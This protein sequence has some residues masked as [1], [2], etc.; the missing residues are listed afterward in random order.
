MREE[1]RRAKGAST[2]WTVNLVI[3][4]ALNVMNGQKVLSVHGNDD[5]VP[6]LRHQN[7]Q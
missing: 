6:D 7:L 5:R 2:V 1:G 3:E 4:Q